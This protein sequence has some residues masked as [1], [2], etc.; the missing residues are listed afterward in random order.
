VVQQNNLPSNER[1]LTMQLVYGVLRQRDV[2]DRALSLLSTTPIRKLD[3]FV[4]QAL[5]VG[6]FQI[7]FLT[8]IPESAAVNEAV[9][10]CKTAKIHRRLH[11]FVNGVL[12]QAI[13]T[14]EELLQ[15]SA[16]NNK[17]DAILNHPDWMVRR[18]QTLFGKEATATF[19]ANNNTP[20]ILTLRVNTTRI[21]RTEY[22]AQLA[23]DEIAALPGEFS[24][25]S[26][27]LP[28]FS[29]SIASLPGYDPG[30]FQ[31]QDQAAQ[32][33]T[34]LLAPY[35]EQ[36]NYLDGCA[37]LGGKTSHLLQEL[38][39][40]GAHVHAVDPEPFRLNKLEENIQ[41]LFSE[42]P[43]TIY[44]KSL[45]D[46]NQSELPLF[47]GIL[48]DAPCSGTGVVGRHPDIRW[49]RQLEDLAIYQS[50]QLALLSHAAT[51]L[52]VGGIL[53][54]ATCSLE[55]EENSEVTQRF[56]QNNQNYELTDCSDL[57]PESAHQFVRNGFF[58]PLPTATIDGFFAARFIKTK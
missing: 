11:G 25:D 42:A 4:H 53:V 29:G 10:S 5:A 8:R 27:V 41:R 48:I 33:A 22:L 36:G 50:E 16:T 3:P 57:L 55:P 39:P 23:T 7:L 15:K 35:K 58:N 38:I 2:L 24:K 47:D 20:P 40:R 45:L 28:D 12:R 26:I 14:K 19:C 34:T 32:I 49:N 13:R 1:N 21:S 6:L 37:G 46:L 56:L 30:F 9:N 54:Y 51:L 18:W 17:K 43:L 31:V 52:T 44:K